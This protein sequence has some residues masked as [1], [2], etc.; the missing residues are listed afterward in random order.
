MK[1]VDL[2]TSSTTIG[3]K[4]LVLLGK[5]IQKDNVQLAQMSIFVLCRCVGKRIP[6]R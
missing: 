5:K 6:H 2:A 4:K 3:H 1:I